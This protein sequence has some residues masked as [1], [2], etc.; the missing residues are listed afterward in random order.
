MTGDPVADVDSGPLVLHLIN[1]F[2]NAYADKLEG[3][4]VKE[5]AIDL[6]GG[7]RINYIFH[8]LFRKVIAQIDPFE[9]LTEQEI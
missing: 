9:Y 4:F 8:D 3:R 5:A 7:S 6:S 1:L 2:I